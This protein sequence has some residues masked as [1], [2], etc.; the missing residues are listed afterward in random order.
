MA[1]LLH[2]ILEHTAHYCAADCAQKPVIDFVSREH[3]GGAAQEAA[4]QTALT[5]FGIIVVRRRLVFYAWDIVVV[6]G[7]AETLM[8]I[9][10]NDKM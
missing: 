8:I 3:A 7:I 9:G 1:V 2:L 6:L 5:G 4:S 10:M